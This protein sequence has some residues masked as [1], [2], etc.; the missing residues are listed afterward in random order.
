[1]AEKEEE[2]KVT[3]T[4]D[5]VKAIVLEGIEEFKKA[6][7]VEA[8]AS[9]LVV[10]KD[11]GDNEFTNIAE[12]A[13]AI[14]A[15]STTYG[16]EKDVRLD[17]LAVKG[18][19]GANEG[20]PSAGG[21]LLEPTLVKEIMAPVHEVGPFSSAAKRLP[22]SSD[23]NYGWING[24]DET[25]RVDGSRWGGLQSYWVAEAA[26]VTATKPAFRRINWELHKIMAICYATDELLKDAS[27]FSAILRQGAAEEINFKI[28]DAIFRGNGT[29]KP[30][31]ILN[32]G[33]LLQTTKETDQTADTVVVENLNKMWQ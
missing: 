17:R 14:K 2:V 5:E 24:V 18:G 27:Q 1:M 4:P 21:F 26:T 23:S 11:E 30:L 29:G 3:M 19:T 6:Y 7:P 22:V 12:Q 32:S 28:N 16:R 15:F 20:L 10:T 9:T 31:G 13:R 25:S 8:P 33:A